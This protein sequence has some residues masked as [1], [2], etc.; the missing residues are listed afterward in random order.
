[1]WAPTGGISLLVM[2]GLSTG[3]G[4]PSPQTSECWRTS[5]H[6]AH[7][8]LPSSEVIVEGCPQFVF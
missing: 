4:L 6:L 7:R 1:M 5:V 8:S 2:E 3:V